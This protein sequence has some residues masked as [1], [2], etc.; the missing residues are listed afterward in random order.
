MFFTQ[1]GR[2]RPA[3][4]IIVVF[5]VLLAARC[6]PIHGDDPPIDKAALEEMGEKSAKGI[7]NL[8]S[9]DQIQTVPRSSD[10][11]LELNFLDIAMLLDGTQIDPATIYGVALAGPYPFEAAETRFAYKRF[12]IY[13]RISEGIGILDLSR[14]TKPR[15]NSEGWTNGGRVCLRLELYAEREG[16][17]LRLGKYDTFV[18]FLADG[19]AVTK[20]PTLVLGPLVCLLHSDDPTRVVI[21]LATDEPSRPSVVLDDGRKFTAE[22]SSRR[23]HIEITGLKAGQSYSY[24]AEIGETKTRSYS[25]ETAPPPGDGPVRFAYL[26]DSRAGPGL[27]FN[28][29]MGVN[30]RTFEALVANAYR[31]DAMFLLVGGDLVSGHTTVREDF[32]TQ[33]HAWKQIVTPFWSERSVYP[34]VG[35][36]DVL[37]R[38]FDGMQVDSWPYD[39][40][41]TEAI[42]AETFANPANGPEPSN[43]R[44]PRYDETVFSFRYGFVKVIAFNNNYWYSNKPHEVGG[45]PEGYIFDDQ[46][47]WIKAEIVAADADPSVRYVVMYAQEPVFPCGGHI[48]DSMWYHGDNNVRAYEMTNNEGSDS[49]LK[50]AAKGMIE[51]RNELVRAIAASPKVAAVLAGDEH[52]FHRILIDKN[53]PVGD[54]ATDD[55]DGDGK[56]ETEKEPASPLRDLENPTWYLTSGGA[57]A[58]YYTEEPTPWTEY[59]LEQE[60]AGSDGFY[61]SSQENLLFFEATD[62]GISVKVYS[63]RGELIDSI[64]DLMD[65]KR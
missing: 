42:F 21:E 65:V 48:K 37:V 64:G 55:L 35:N 15:A 53:V 2:S 49:G 20:L 57:G 63:T 59:W 44:R 56:I 45:S 29:F 23:H 47:S 10:K 3:V 27:G 13:G 52:S 30:E 9:I 1:T 8:L 28:S 12:R 11:G 16:R 18:E 41:G 51:V 58:P 50:A 34:C 46:L 19:K 4:L 40:E 26:G 33:L 38:A 7:S 54:M 60:K 25:F 31:D 6:G 61:Y 17:D 39:T 14:L 43:P 24:F 36:H 22:S 32:E 5:A 62:A